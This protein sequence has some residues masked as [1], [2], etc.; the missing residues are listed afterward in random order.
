M[1]KDEDNFFTTAKRAVSNLYMQEIGDGSVEITSDSQ[2][3][4]ALTIEHIE[5]RIQL[6]TG[7]YTIRINR[8]PGTTRPD[9]VGYVASEK[10]SWM[11]LL[12]LE[13]REFLLLLIGKLKIL[14][15]PP[16]PPDAGRLGWLAYTSHLREFQQLPVSSVRSIVYLLLLHKHPKPGMAA[17]LLFPSSCM[18]H[19]SRLYDEDASKTIEQ[20]LLALFITRAWELF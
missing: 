19:V 8:L 16:S 2:T 7:G 4:I 1:P 17:L 6:Q 18:L 9:P 13:F 12:L 11:T 14:P 10:V 20:D 3:F 15:A 5:L